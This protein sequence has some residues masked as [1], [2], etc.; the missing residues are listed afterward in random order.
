M[1]ISC[2]VFIM[3]CTNTAPHGAICSLFIIIKPR[4]GTQIMA[5]NTL[6]LGSVFKNFGQKPP[7]DLADLTQGYHSLLSGA[8]GSTCILC[9]AEKQ[10]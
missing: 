7:P 2:R 6:G 9:T 4:L 3:Q 8:T 1:N 5:F 10:K